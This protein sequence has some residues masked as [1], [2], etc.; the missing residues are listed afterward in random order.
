MKKTIVCDIDGTLTRDTVFP[1]V[2]VYE[3]RIP[4]KESVDII[5]QLYAKGYRIILHSARWAED[6]EITVRWLMTHGVNYHELVLEK[7]LGAVSF[8][9]RSIP[10]VLPDMDKYLSYDFHR[11]CSR[12]QKGGVSK[13]EE[14][15]CFFCEYPLKMTLKECKE[16]GIII[17][18]N[19]GRCLCNIPFLSYLTLV[20]VHE[21][22]CCNLD[23]F[24][25][26][27]ELDGFVDS[28]L[29][30]RCERIL[31]TCKKYQKEVE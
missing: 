11:S 9:D 10:A 17:C 28:S 22:Y 14:H 12:Y 19:C 7:P 5:N 3:K 26:K 2:S 15:P 27:I 16:C 25:G 23:G 13:E 4:N 20:R 1:D 21:K 31:S 18:P 24:D 8:D 29:M 6:I 30:K